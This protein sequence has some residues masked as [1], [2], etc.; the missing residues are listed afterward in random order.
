MKPKSAHAG[1]RAIS[2]GLGLTAAFI[3]LGLFGAIAAGPSLGGVTV[4]SHARRLR[5]AAFA[6][7]GSSTC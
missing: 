7:S 2:A 6:G 5:Y 3:N 1:T 4:G